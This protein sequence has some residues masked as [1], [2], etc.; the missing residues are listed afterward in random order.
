MTFV[1]PSSANTTADWS[2]S[3]T[4]YDTTDEMDS[5]LNDM[6][7]SQGLLIDD[8]G[9]ADFSFRPMSGKEKLLAAVNQF[10]LSRL[11]LLICL[12]I[13][14]LSVVTLV[15]STMVPYP[16]LKVFWVMEFAI[17]SFMIFEVSVRIMSL[18]V[19]VFFRYWTNRLDILLTVVC[20][21][22][23]IMYSHGILTNDKDE[24]LV[25]EE[26]ELVLT[27]A[28]TA[29]QALRLYHLFK[30][31]QASYVQKIDLVR[32]VDSSRSI[33]SPSTATNRGRSPSHAMFG[34]G[35]FNV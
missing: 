3:I 20:T 22:M 19:Q 35:D 31:Q 9:L 33:A 14:A 18:G 2:S 6:Q 24:A 27:I 28:R 7:F 12:G 10:L 17:V 16:D 13:I 23:L 26:I 29:I 1:S 11:Y 4:D 32:V 30:R 15:W 5:M 25:E 34:K 8:E 21:I